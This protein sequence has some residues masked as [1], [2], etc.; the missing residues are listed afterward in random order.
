ML[1]HKVPKTFHWDLT[2]LLVHH[3]FCWLVISKD[4]LKISAV[5][6]CSIIHLHFTWHLSHYINRSHVVSIWNTTFVWNPKEKNFIYGNMGYL[7]YL[8]GWKYIFWKYKQYVLKL[9]IYI[10]LAIKMNFENFKD[11]NLRTFGVTRFSTNL[12]DLIMKI[13]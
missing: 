1:E 9:S 5:C 4:P 11:V 3:I 10:I 8:H 6:W 2:G 12:V 7:R 13:L